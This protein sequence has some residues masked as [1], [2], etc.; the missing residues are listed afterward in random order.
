MSPG[1][2]ASLVAV[3]FLPLCRQLTS[4]R[5]CCCESRKA[6]RAVCVQGSWNTGEQSKPCFSSPRVLP[7]CRPRGKLPAF[8]GKQRSTEILYVLSKTCR[9]R[10]SFLLQVYFGKYLFIFQ[11]TMVE[12]GWERRRVGVPARYAERHFLPLSPPLEVLSAGFR[13]AACVTAAEIARKDTCA[14][15]PARGRSHGRWGRASQQNACA[16]ERRWSQN[17]TIWGRGLPWCQPCRAAGGGQLEQVLEFLG[18]VF[19][20]KKFARIWV[21]TYVELK[22]LIITEYELK[23]Y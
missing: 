20:R 11:Q 18:S 1:V 2:R 3:S 22:Y 21:C 7:R 4:P 13:S 6:R 19:L 9:I 14:G 17:K 5:F 8:W 23:Y 12:A 10:P 16:W 15:T